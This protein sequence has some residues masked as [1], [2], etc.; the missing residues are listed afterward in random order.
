MPIQS[1]ESRETGR[2]GR[3]WT[4]APKLWAETKSVNHDGVRKEW[5][6]GQR[7]GAAQ[8]TSRFLTALTEER[9]SVH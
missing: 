2:P 9:T 4:T 8:M 7:W 1:Q 3:R 5:Y 6:G